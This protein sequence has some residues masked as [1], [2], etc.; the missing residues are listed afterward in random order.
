MTAEQME[1]KFENVLVVAT[2][3]DYRVKVVRN[4]MSISSD[5]KIFHIIKM[6][7]WFKIN[8]NQILSKRRYETT[9]ELEEVVIKLL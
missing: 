5:E 4:K 2:L 3:M 8:T 6:S 7:N 9:D 1:K